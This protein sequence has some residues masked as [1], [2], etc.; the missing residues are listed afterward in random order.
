MHLL[1]EIHYILLNTD[2]N[3]YLKSR[4]F[5]SQAAWLPMTRG[6]RLGVGRKPI[7]LQKYAFKSIRAVVKS[8]S[9]NFNLCVN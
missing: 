9:E 5:H 4:I 7:A 1:T 6:D 2:Y 3:L 8:K